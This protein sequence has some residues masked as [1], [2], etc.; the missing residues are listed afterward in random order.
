M[1]LLRYFFFVG[2]DLF[3]IDHFPLLGPTLEDKE[4]NESPAQ[5]F[6]LH[7]LLVEIVSLVFDNLFVSH[8]SR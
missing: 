5:E 6:E 1:E 2:F 4:C 7:V 8:Y 3:L